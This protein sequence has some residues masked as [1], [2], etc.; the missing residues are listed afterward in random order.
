MWGSKESNQQ[1]KEG[2]LAF[3]SIRNKY[4]SLFEDKKTV[5]NSL[6]Q[7][8]ADEMTDMGYNLG[9]GGAE[10]CRQKF[11]N[12]QKTYMGHVKHMKTTGEKKRDPPLYFDEKHSILDI[13][14]NNI[15]ML[16]YKYLP[17]RYLSVW[18]K[19]LEA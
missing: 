16:K 8:I 17:C 3:L 13:Y 2:T 7:R 9:A 11:A 6:W 10:K 18:Y 12:L 1:D 14:L 19:S 4:S 5:K 15:F